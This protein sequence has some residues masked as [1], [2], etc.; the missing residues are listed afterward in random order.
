M[1]PSIDKT[2]PRA[3]MICKEVKEADDFQSA[4]KCNDC[5]SEIAAVAAEEYRVQNLP[6]GRLVSVADILGGAWTLMERKGGVHVPMKQKYIRMK[7][8]SPYFLSN[9]DPPAIAATVTDD[10]TKTALRQKTKASMAFIPVPWCLEQLGFKLCTKCP[11][12]SNIR[13]LSDFNPQGTGDQ[14][15][16]NCKSCQGTARSSSLAVAGE[17]RAQLVA[18][19]GTRE[20]DACHNVKSVISFSV[21]HPN[22]CNSC[23]NAASMAR[24]EAKAAEK[25]DEYRMC[26]GCQVAHPLADFDEDNRTCR[27]KLARSAGYDAMPER[28]AYHAALNKQKKYWVRFRANKRRENESEYLMHNAAI[29]SAWYRNNREHVAQWRS[30]SL[31]TK[32]ST[33]RDGALQRGIQWELTEDQAVALIIAE[34]VY[35]GCVSKSGAF[36]GIDRVNSDLAY[37]PSNCVPACTTC[38]K[39]KGCLDVLTFLERASHLASVAVGGPHERYPD[40]WV[41]RAPCSF[42]QYHARAKAKGFGWELT[43]EEFAAVQAQACSMCLRPG[44]SSVDRTDNVPVYSVDTV[45]PLCTECNYMKKALSN[46]DFITHVV[47]I[48]NHGALGFFETVEVVRQKVSNLNTYVNRVGAML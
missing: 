12:D 30:E 25:P 21:D 22:R 41:D 26:V 47:K 46:T 9:E 24:G 28:R 17:V 45:L 3:C 27:K 7:D 13:P 43:Q 38:N 5:E 2:K 39:M 42:D 48:A 14:L 32:A 19:G 35:C 34:C 29:H 33:S 40:A 36:G 31:S 37:V 10:A 8:L 15:R 20:C 44:P 16:G 1:P 18:A 6:S 4:R 11:E 23:R